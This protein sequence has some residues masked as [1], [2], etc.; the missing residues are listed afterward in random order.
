MNP[1]YEDPFDNN[2]S[3]EQLRTDKI[4]SFIYIIRSHIP[5]NQI[6]YLLFFIFKYNIP[7]LATN[8][9][10]GKEDKVFSLSKIIQKITIFGN[11]FCP[12]KDSYAYLCLVLFLLMLIY[13]SVVIV[14]FFQYLRNGKGKQGI[15]ILSY[16]LLV[17]CF[18]SQYFCELLIPGILSYSFRMKTFDE[19]SQ[20]KEEFIASLVN[21]TTIPKYILT[22]M[23]IFSFFI[24]YMLLYFFL[25]FINSP[26]RSFKH[27]N[28]NFNYKQIFNAQFISY[29]FQGFITCSELYDK[30][31]KDLLRLGF[32]IGTFIL[33]TFATFSRYR[34]F[35]YYTLNFPLQYTIFACFLIVLGGAIEIVLFFIYSADEI[36][37]LYYYLKLSVMGINSFL[38]SYYFKVNLN[39]YFTNQLIAKIF[40][41]KNKMTPGD[42]AMYDLM[43][44]NYLND[45]CDFSELY[46]IYHTHKVKCTVQKC[47]CKI[48]EIDKWIDRESITDDNEHYLIVKLTKK[49]EEFK[50]S[51]I[52]DFIEIAEYEIKKN[53]MLIKK[54]RKFSNFNQ[55]LL[56]LLHLDII[57]LLKKDNCIAMYFCDRYRAKAH[58]IN[59]VTKYYLYEYKILISKELALIDKISSIER[60]LNEKREMT[61]QMKEF[62]HYAEFMEKV[63]K[64]IINCIF[65]L[66]TI[67]KYK[68]KQSMKN[69]SIAN[70]ISCDQFLRISEDIQTTNQK[71]TRSLRDYLR[72]KE[73]DN[74]ELCILVCY[75][76]LML[77]QKAP[78]KM[79]RKMDEIVRKGRNTSN[80]P[81]EGVELDENGMASDDDYISQLAYDNVNIS[82]PMIVILNC[83]DN[84]IIIHIT[85]KMCSLLKEGKREI[86]KNDLHNYLPKD[87]IK[88]HKII[89]K[90]FLLTS[91]AQFIKDTFI[92]DKL[93]NLI[94]MKIVCNPLNTLETNFGL[95][96]NFVEKE[97]KPTVYN[98][99]YFLLN[100]E[101][102][103]LGI[104]ELFSKEYFF[105]LQM[106]KI[107]HLDFCTFFGIKAEKLNLRLR[108]FFLKNKLTN[109]NEFLEEANKEMSVFTLSKMETLF[110]KEKMKV[111]GRKAQP[112]KVKEKIHKKDVITNLTQLQKNINDFGLDVEWYSRIGD[113][114]DRLLVGIENYTN[115]D[116]DVGKKISF[117]N[118][119]E[120]YYTINSIGN[121]HYIIVNLRE[122]LNNTVASGNGNNAANATITAGNPKQSGKKTKLKMN[123]TTDKDIKRFDLGYG[124][125]NQND[126]EIFS[127]NSRKGMLPKKGQTTLGKT[128]INDMSGSFQLMLKE[129]EGNS[130]LRGKIKK[131]NSNSK[132]KD[133]KRKQDN[134]R[135][136]KGNNNNNNNQ[137][138]T[139]ENEENDD[140]L[141]LETRKLFENKSMY[142]IMD[143]I[144]K[145]LIVIQFVCCFLWVI[146]NENDFRTSFELYFINLYSTNIQ[147]D[148]FY[149]SMS[150]FAKCGLYGTLSEEQLQ[151]ET[152][153]LE[154]LASE[155]RGHTKLF[156][157]YI[158]NQIKKKELEKIFTIL[159]TDTR[160]NILLSNK[161]L[162]TVT[163]SFYE[164]LKFY[165]YNIY[166]LAH[167]GTFTEC[168]LDDLNSDSGFGNQEMRHVYYIIHNLPLTISNKFNEIA[169]MAQ[170]IFENN[171]NTS[172]KESYIFV[173]LSIGIEIILMILMQYIMS[174]HKTNTQ[175]LLN[176]IYTP[177]RND[178]LLE[179]DLYNYKELLFNF[180]KE[181]YIHFRSMHTK[182]L[183]NETTSGTQRS[184][185][186]SN[187]N[188]LENNNNNIMNDATNN[189]TMYKFSDNAT[190]PKHYFITTF[191]MYVA[192]VIFIIL[193]ASHIINLNNFYERFLKSNSISLNFVELFPKIIEMLMYTRISVLVNNPH[194]INVPLE[195]YKNAT[196]YQYYDF[197]STDRVQ[198]IIDKYGTSSFSYLYYQTQ[199][200]R[201]NIDKFMS[202]D[203]NCLPQ[204]QGWHKKFLLLEDNFC[205][206]SSLGV[207]YSQQSQ[208]YTMVFETMNQLVKE[209]R[210][211]GG[212]INLHDLNTI[213]DAVVF[214]IESLFSE[215]ILGYQLN[216]D[217]TKL[218]QD[219]EMY[220]IESNLKGQLKYVYSTYVNCTM[221]DIDQLV[222]RA[223]TAEI[224]FAFGLFVSAAFYTIIVMIL[225][226]SSNSNINVLVYIKSFM[227]Q[228]LTSKDS[229]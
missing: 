167:Y 5:S 12:L 26:T 166:Q 151:D 55:D 32:C 23:N 33:Y 97:L 52:S 214:K 188:N 177:H 4:F 25:M 75:Y 1:S 62:Y 56:V 83:D 24:I 206:Y 138:R 108:N 40:I 13:I 84:F 164:E 209:C 163:T 191:G 148:I 106:M 10:R 128:K 132:L 131:T 60:E 48:L 96:I 202:D 19:N 47:P 111:L 80:D 70:L 50:F 212:G 6:F 147:T 152:E 79:V 136:G 203:S 134:K 215:F 100:N 31:T 88:M 36:P 86:L 145:L 170:E 91:S 109:A 8:N 217:N 37:T 228:A 117:L 182:I 197:S 14:L 222:K 154:Y 21:D 223:K 89:M 196:I 71:L 103:F 78:K 200:I 165:Q 175:I 161:Q 218:L 219:E 123:P 178:Y 38:L 112:L 121:F 211:Y 115:N 139:D 207:L 201:R 30:S 146:F 226:K 208:N 225:L 44:Y 142:V 43:L 195:E 90:Q 150:I 53:I 17:F 180:T 199:Q 102:H 104:N 74:L 227:F 190:V 169:R 107:I 92:M 189:E 73:P 172:R 149:S 101:F 27:G 69:L 7:I 179:E 15:I 65:A 34:E 160:L 159:N 153:K 176:H 39:L 29:S 120:A 45:K 162:E 168:T 155:L 105:N 119:F 76:F 95:V 124:D 18:F 54:E 183:C 229:R 82:N 143:Y 125:G 157:N 81:I 63:K 94:P 198:N 193:Q 68:R 173:F 64:M 133:K 72:T 144:W 118:Y 135:K 224:I 93:H 3:K 158:N 58:K 57:Y 35:N 210:I 184:M 113:F 127:I 216:S 22:L 122:M 171:L 116:N 205:I 16:F 77:N 174:D 87:I 28:L 181:S 137:N 85:M 140:T 49:R 114:R 126:K 59:F 51:S 98:D 213:I 204:T 186:S 192:G 221:E 130:A 129:D 66:E 9:I 20:C 194:M 41:E 46:H 61:K 156:V 2:A 220:I 187:D 141:Q 99:Y 67:L 11:S 110:M 42:L 185:T